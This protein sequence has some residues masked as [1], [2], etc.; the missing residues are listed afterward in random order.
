[1]KVK[2]EPQNTNPSWGPLSTGKLVSFSRNEAIDLA[3]HFSES[4][5]ITYLK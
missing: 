5:S 2:K 4:K 1:M 3:K